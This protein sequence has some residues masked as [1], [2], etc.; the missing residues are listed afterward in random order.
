M[1]IWN[2][3]ADHAFGADGYNP[4]T[5]VGG[6]GSGSWGLFMIDG[7]DT[8]V[9]MGLKDIADR[10]LAHIAA[11]D[12]NV[13]ADPQIDGF[14]TIIRLIGGLLSAYDLITSGLVPYADQYD[15]TQVPK[16]LDGARTLADFISPLYDT[17][18]GLPYFWINTTTRVGFPGFF[19]NT[20]V[21]G[22]IILEY[23]RLSDL[24][25]DTKYRDQ[26]DK[27]ESYLLNPNP[28]P[29][30]PA[31]VGSNVNL[32]TGEFTNENA[33]WQSGL[34]SFYEYLIKSVV[35]DPTQPLAQSY[36]DFWTTAVESTQ[37]H[38]ISHPY[39]HDELTF[40]MTLNNTGTPQYEMDDYSCFAG[41]NWLLGGAYLG[42]PDFMDLGLAL[43][44]SCHALYNT[45]PSG[46]NPLTIG[47]YGPDNVAYEEQY[48]NGSAAAQQARAEFNERGYFIR[49][50]SYGDLNTL[51]PEPIESMMYAWRITGN[52]IWQEH[53][54]EIFQAM[55]K[56]G[57]RPPVPMSSLYNVSAPN[58]GDQFP[59]V[60]R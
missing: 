57:N 59:D 47:W 55:Q 4:L 21:D 46:L 13:T 42:R 26:A 8:A 19:D 28:P 40:V 18:T 41:G 44:D 34:D 25:G 39:G 52:P 7:I 38:L 53:N 48:N 36:R 33:G 56:D 50:D 45:T 27:A 3:Y 9:V 51:Y 31:L 23:H 29:I 30:Y 14:D 20:A 54:W 16:L 1:D 60:P 58:G 2:D 6:N 32:T 49:H 5:Q 24:T 10:Q 35:Y 12:F 11:Q 43:S 22:T 17:P 37:Q 15:K